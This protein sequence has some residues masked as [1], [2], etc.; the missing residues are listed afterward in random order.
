MPGFKRIVFTAPIALG[1][2]EELAIEYDISGQSWTV[3]AVK[4]NDQE[5]EFSVSSK[6]DSPK[7]QKETTW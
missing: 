6:N 7:D 1:P 2:D 3:S 5:I 4:L